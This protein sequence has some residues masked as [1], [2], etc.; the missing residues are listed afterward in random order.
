MYAALVLES[1][2]EPLFFGKIFLFNIFLFNILKMNNQ[3]LTQKISPKLAL[4]FVKWQYMADFMS[5]FV[6]K[7]NMHIRTDIR[8]KN[9]SKH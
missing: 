8:I 7:S 4:L 1:I 5:D 6:I 2:L 9:F 3:E